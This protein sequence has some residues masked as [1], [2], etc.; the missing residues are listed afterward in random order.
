M[1]IDMSRFVARFAEE[2][3]E[4]ITAL[5][6]GIVALEQAPQDTEIITKVSGFIFPCVNP[7]LGISH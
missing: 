4:H 3:R 2:G 7:N 5:E 1:A 6:K